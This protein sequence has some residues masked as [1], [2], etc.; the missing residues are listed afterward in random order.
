MRRPLASSKDRAIFI[1]AISVLFTLG[2][3]YWYAGRASF[4]PARSHTA[5]LH[6]VVSS[7]K[8]L[9]P[10]ARWD[11]VWYFLIAQSGYTQSGKHGI[12]TPGFFPGYPMIIR[13][14]STLTSIDLF[15][16]AIVAAVLGYLL[17]QYLLYAFL[18]E[19]GSTREEACRSV[20]ALA[21][22]PTAFLLQSGYSESW[23]LAFSL[24]AF[25]QIRRH[26]YGLAAICALLAGITRPHATILA[27]ALLCEGYHQFKAIKRRLAWVPGL[28]T[29]LGLGGFQ[30]YLTLVTHDRLAYF[31]SKQAGGWNSSLTHV[32]AEFPERFKNA[33]ALILV[34]P[35]GLSV[36]LEYIVAAGI[37]A[38]GISLW[39]RKKIP[40]S[41]LLLGCVAL[42]YAGG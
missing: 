26:S 18:K 2:S 21:C 10:L 38:S 17:S 4:Q 42:S 30:L 1:T 20:V 35:W 24:G 6:G 27:L 39:R 36:F 22:F 12:S 11:T 9:P 16:S 3:S 32:V 23:F 19:N 37:L 7:I 28:S 33:F 40:E 15:T 25:L 14:I 31:H 34:N 8:Q 13:L 5:F 29:L 41:L